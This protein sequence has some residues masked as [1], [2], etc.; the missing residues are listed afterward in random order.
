MQ[1]LGVNR[2]VL[3]CKGISSEAADGKGLAN[4]SRKQHKVL[5]MRCPAWA[6]LG[7]FGSL[8]CT[9][10]SFGVKQVAQHQ[11]FCCY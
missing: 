5:D 2:S 10:P 6:A 4:G 9:G 3:V 11:A 1:T 8:F 7:G